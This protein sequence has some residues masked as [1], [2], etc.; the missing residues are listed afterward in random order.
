MIIGILR[1]WVLNIG[2]TKIVYT[3]KLTNRYQYYYAKGKTLVWEGGSIFY[4]LPRQAFLISQSTAS[5]YKDAV[6]KAFKSVD[7][8]NNESYTLSLTP[9]WFD[10]DYRDRF[11][12]DREY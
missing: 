7:V 8:G 9:K 5:I 12:R 1:W 2:E 4:V 10:F 3:P 11:Y 6:S